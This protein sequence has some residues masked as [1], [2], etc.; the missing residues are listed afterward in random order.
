MHFGKNICAN[1]NVKLVEAHGVNCTDHG[2]CW[3]DDLDRCAQERLVLY[4]VPQGTHASRFA[5]LLAHTHREVAKSVHMV[6]KTN[7][8]M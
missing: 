1:I 3:V 4:S 7:F 8:H 6:Q 2:G 5:L